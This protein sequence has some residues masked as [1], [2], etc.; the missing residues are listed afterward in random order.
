MKSKQTLDPREVAVTAVMTALTAVVTYFTGS[1][2]PFPI[3][4]GYLNLGDALVMLSGLLFG[5]R[6]GGFA[7]GVGSALSDAI[8]APYYAPLTLF[9]KGTE[10]YLAGLIGNDR[11][12]SRRIAGVVAGACAMLAG[13][14]SVETPLINMGA[15]LGE[16]ITINWIQVTIGGVVAI[17]LAQGVV[18]AYPNIEFLKPKAARIRA[19]ILMVI[20][21]IVVLGSIVGVYLLTGAQ[22]FFT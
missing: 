12:L 11:K 3:T 13:Y 22:R 16:L 19:G 15:A 6:V 5:A 18:R 8:L 20:V 9:I 21:A 17:L 4:G 1:L 7:G 14:F 2:F 10:G